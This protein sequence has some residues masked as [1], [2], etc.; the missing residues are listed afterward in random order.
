MKNLIKK[1]LRETV[2]NS[3][4]PFW[5]RVN[6]GMS[7][8]KGSDI[9]NWVME[10]NMDE[11]PDFIK[12]CDGGLDLEG[13]QIQTLGNL[14]SVGRNLYLRDTPI[15][16]LGNLESV[17]G[18]LDLWRTP[19]KN[20]GNL[21]SVG[22]SLDLRGTPIEDLGNLQSIGGYLDLWRTPISKKYSKQE[23]RSQ[24]QVGG[25]IYL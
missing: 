10:Y 5:K 18:N 9:I 16:D 4:D 11:I 17:G 1:I 2:N 7:Y 19:I 20:L 14:E 8:A 13:T 22:G 3:D 12:H 15:E 6:D 25:D 21:Q 24:V 23:I